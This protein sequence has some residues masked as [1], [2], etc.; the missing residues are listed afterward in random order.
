[1]AGASQP[2]RE[3]APLAKLIE[4]DEVWEGVNVH[5][6][7]MTLP[8]NDPAVLFVRDNK[9]LLVPRQNEREIRYNPTQGER[10]EPIEVLVKERLATLR[11]HYVEGSP[12][13]PYT[14]REIC[15]GVTRIPRHPKHD[16]PNQ[17]LLLI[18]HQPQGTEYGLIYGF[19]KLT[20]ETMLLT[21]PASML[22]GG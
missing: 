16:D 8:F 18:A 12:I 3:D 11:K 21:S 5:V 22:F 10:T 9:R 14:P 13:E 6:I 19:D 7:E 2:V 20:K 1:V 4:R 17:A 15:A